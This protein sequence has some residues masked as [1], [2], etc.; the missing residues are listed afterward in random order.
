MP[1]TRFWPTLVL[2]ALLLGACS[3][4]GTGS[5]P[6]APPVAG[7]PPTPAPTP[8]APAP[9]PPAPT[10]PAPGVQAAAAVDLAI[11]RGA[12]AAVL[13]ADGAILAER[14]G[15]GGAASRGEL[16]YSGTKSFTCPLILL[17][18]AEGAGSG[19]ELVSRRIAAWAAGGT[20]PDAALK[21][22]IR[23]RDLSALTSG[24]AAEGA[25]GEAV[26]DRDSYAQALSARSTAA[27][28]TATIYTPNNH[29]ALAAWYELA[30]GGAFDSAGVIR[31]GRDG[32]ER[33]QAG[34]F[35]ALGVRPTDWARDI[36]GKPN[37]GS[38]AEMTA[39]D[40]ARFGQMVAED[41][42]FAGVQ[43]LPADGMRRCRDYRSGA[44]Q[45]Y[46][47]GWWLNR[48]VG[49]SYRAGRDSLPFPADVQARWAAGGKLAPSAPDDMIMAAGFA[50]RRLFVVPSRRLVFVVIGGSADEEALMRAL[51]G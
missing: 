33:L 6:A 13:I 39:R 7:A 24:L 12:R 34:L 47:L 35:A 42:R 15:A 48:P 27:P 22:G 40:W 25:I 46:G 17:A 31:G 38:G 23:V 49:A 28:D 18:E 51:F 32:V 21:A 2:T 4:G 30:T 43:L 45:G 16:L 37:F 26:N 20:A 29:Q 5:S 1:G 41:G 3:G 9:T 8:P 14:Y 50:N 44:F 10:P 19:D 36:H 11:S